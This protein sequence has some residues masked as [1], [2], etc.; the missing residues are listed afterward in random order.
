MINYMILK[1]TQKWK[2]IRPTTKKF[3]ISEISEFRTSRSENF[4]EY[5][6][7][8]SK[9]FRKDAVGIMEFQ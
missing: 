1:N 9:N 5:A 3:P 7:Y 8:L 2:F 4:E 6:K